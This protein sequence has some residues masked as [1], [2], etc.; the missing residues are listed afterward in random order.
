M[1]KAATPKETAAVEKKPAAR[2]PAAKTAAA[3]KAAGPGAA[4][5][6][7]GG[8]H[9]EGGATLV[10]VEVPEHVPHRATAEADGREHDGGLAE[11]A[12]RG[13]AGHDGELH[14]FPSLGF[15]K[16]DSDLSDNGSGKRLAVQRGCLLTPLE[17]RPPFARRRSRRHQGHRRSARR[18]RAD[19]RGRPGSVRRGP[20]APNAGASAAR[21]PAGPPSWERRSEED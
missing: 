2:K 15:W 3:T 5:P 20:S 4:G 19:L 6:T 11:P 21:A 9:T 13:I 1:A 18:S 16:L 7:G 12:G 8:T 14:G 17:K 10:L